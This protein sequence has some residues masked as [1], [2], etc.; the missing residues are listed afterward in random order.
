MKT[1]MLAPDSETAAEAPESLNAGAVAHVRPDVGKVAELA[2]SLWEQRGCPS[3][4][5]DEDWFEAERR[6]GTS[7]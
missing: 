7:S 4:C 6:L 2:H 3:D 1:K 5:P